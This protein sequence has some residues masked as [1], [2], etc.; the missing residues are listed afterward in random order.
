MPLLEV[1]AAWLPDALQRPLS[2]AALR[3]LVMAGVVRVAGRPLRR[4][5]APVRAGLAIT[6]EVRLDRLAPPAAPFELAPERILYEDEWLIAVDKPAGLPTH[7][8]ADRLRP[9]L[10]D[11]VER[12]LGARGASDRLGVHQRLDRDTSGVVLFAKS[13]AANPGLAA[14]FG[15]RRVVKVYRAL[16]ARPPRAASRW[17]S[18]DDVHGQPA[19]TDF[20]VLA[21]LPRALLL[22]ARPR[23]GRKH[24]IRVHLALA[25]MPILGDR[26]YGGAAPGLPHAARVMLHAARLELLHPVT[27]SR[28]VLESPEPPDFR[29]LRASL[30]RRRTG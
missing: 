20:E 28:L 8:G 9:N 7:V 29:K 2:R 16:T 11:A 22:E 26:R 12:V 4:P 1:L 24:Q 30:R 6:A 25:G 15:E 18:D 19:Q 17:T 14:A 3:R 23:T 21:T 5:G 10:V 27:L 13:A